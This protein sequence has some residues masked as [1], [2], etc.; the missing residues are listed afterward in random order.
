MS[1]V[2]PDMNKETSKTHRAEGP[3]TGEMKESTLVKD[4][5]AGSPSQDPS[6]PERRSGADRRQYERVLVD[7]S[8]DY[9]ASDTFLFAYISD[10]SAMGIFV[11]TPKPE[12]PGTRLNLRFTPPG[13]DAAPLELEGKVT[14]I[15]PPRP[16]HEGGQA[17]GRQPG[18]GIQFIDLTPAQRDLLMKLVRTFAYL[19]DEDE[20]DRGDAEDDDGEVARGHS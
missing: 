15:N 2:Q 6:R 11:R 14:W 8:V 7:W 5:R 3:G 19:N 4:R 13:V 9:R 20:D 16:V 1:A 17:E 18:M 12:A 10:I